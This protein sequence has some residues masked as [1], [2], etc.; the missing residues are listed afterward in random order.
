MKTYKIYEITTKDGLR[1]IGQTVNLSRRISNHKSGDN[2]TPLKRGEY[3]SYCI[4]DELHDEYAATIAEI[5]WIRL[6]EPELNKD[7]GGNLSPKY[8]SHKQLRTIYDKAMRDINEQ[9]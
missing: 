7:M 5:Y 4:L 2:T 8:Y 3:E 1:Y 6:L 9:Q